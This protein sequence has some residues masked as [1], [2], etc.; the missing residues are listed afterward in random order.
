SGQLYITLKPLAERHG[1][2]TFAVMTRLNRAAQAMPGVQMRLR[3]VQDLPSGGG[4]GG[5]GGGGQYQVQL[6]GNDIASLQQ[7]T[8]KLVEALKKVPQLRDVGSDVDESG[9]RQTLVVDR[10]S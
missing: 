5:G 6:K 8:P 4:G 3:P 9:P 2:S 10:D 7:W 1:E